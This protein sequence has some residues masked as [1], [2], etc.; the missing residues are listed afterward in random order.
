[1]PS[2]GTNLWETLIYLC[3]DPGDVM[4]V[5]EEWVSKIC[6][7]SRHF[8]LMKCAHIFQKKNICN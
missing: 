1:M 7:H 2:V 5:L 6:F 3:L 8:C 4:W